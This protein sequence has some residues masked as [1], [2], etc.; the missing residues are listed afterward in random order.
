MLELSRFHSTSGWE[1]RGRQDW[2]HLSYGQMESSFEISTFLH[3][4]VRNQAD[5]GL[6]HGVWRRGYEDC[7]LSEKEA[8]RIKPCSSTSL[9]MKHR[10]LSAISNRL[11]SM[12]SASG[13]FLPTS[14]TQPRSVGPEL[15]PSRQELLMKITDVKEDDFRCRSMVC[16][17]LQT[18][19][20]F[21]F[22]ELSGL[23]CSRQAMPW[24]LRLR[25]EQHGEHLLSFGRWLQS[26]FCL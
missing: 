25:R 15:S 26:D 10:S 11:P 22:R 9:E 17:R 8:Y 24:W 7:K 14:P 1:L 13:R 12:C 2:R 5:W 21:N 18:T 19:V 3:S 20:D 4:C 16:E 23:L 6:P